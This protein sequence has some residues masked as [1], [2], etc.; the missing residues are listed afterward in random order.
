MSPDETPDL[1][2]D[3]MQI[4]VSPFAVILSFTMTPPGQTGTIPPL[5]VANIRTSLEHAKVMAI[6]LRKQLK[7]YEES[8]GATIPLHAQVWQQLGLSR[9]EDW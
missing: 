8:L 2:A 9:Q 3:G 7:S 4:N 6:V 5:R 1:F